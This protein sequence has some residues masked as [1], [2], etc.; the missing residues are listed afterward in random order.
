MKLILPLLFVLPFAG[1]WA[2]TAATTY[3]PPTKVLK[4]KGYQIGLGVDYFSTSKP[5]D[6][7]GKGDTYTDGAKFNRTQAEF[8]GYY[9]VTDDF[10]L[11]VGARLRQN[12]GTYFAV[13]ADGTTAEEQ[14]YTATQ[15]GFQSTSFSMMYAFKPVDKIQYTLEGLFRYVPYTNEDFK[16]NLTERNQ[17][18][19]VLGDEGNEYSGGLGAT[20]SSPSNNHFTFRGGL[21]R[22]G[23]DLSSE[24]YYNA[25]AAFVWTS[26][27]LIGGVDGASSM[28]NSKY[29]SLSDPDRPV[30]N[31]ANTNLYNSVNREYITPY[32]GLNIGLSKYWRVELK[33]SYVAMGKST[34]I[35]TGFGINLVR[36]VDKNETKVIDSKFK[37]YDIEVTVTKV[38]PKKGYLVVDKGLSEDVNKGMV[39]DF[40]EFDYVGGNMLIARGI[41]IKTTADTSIVKITQRFNTKKDIKEGLIGRAYYR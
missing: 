1:C 4:E 36:R 25:E 28:K 38:S 5:V 34:D 6:E 18:D 20:Y 12:S 19:I 41:V 39:F 13:P 30:F 11:G 23:S 9:G 2:Q 32:L 37:T 3:I 27:A 26:V 22:P 14:Q 21:R 33:G 8:L 10:Q 35:G 29:E 24:I 40:F 31:T 7:S 17:N 15:N 16:N